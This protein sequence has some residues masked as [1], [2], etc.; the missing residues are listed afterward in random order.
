MY[1]NAITLSL[2]LTINL[3]SRRNKQWKKSSKKLKSLKLKWL[4]T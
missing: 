1:N 4:W 3:I 2:I